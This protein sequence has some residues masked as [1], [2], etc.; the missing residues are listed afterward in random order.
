MVTSTMPQI[1][2]RI[3][4]EDLRAGDILL[5][6]DVASGHVIL[7]DR[8]ADYAHNSY[9]GFELCPRGTLHHVIPYPYYGGF[10]AYEPYRY[11]NAGD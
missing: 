3:A 11:N 5:N 8:W 7:F 4:K 9:V 6:T 10:G 2:H 1:A